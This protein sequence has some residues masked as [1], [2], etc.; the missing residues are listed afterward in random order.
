MTITQEIAKAQRAA[1]QVVLPRLPWGRGLLLSAA[2]LMLLFLTLP[3]VALVVRAAE[4]YTTWDLPASGIPEAIL[5]SAVTTTIAALLTVIFG[6]PLA[7]LLARHHFP[8]KALIV[9]LV[10][11][12]IVLPPAV[13]GLALLIAFGSQ[14]LLGPS[15]SSLGVRLPFS[16][17]AVMMVQVFVAAPFYIRAAIAAF[18]DIPHEIEDAARVDGASEREVFRWVTLPVVQSALVA[19]LLLSWSR[20]LGEFGATILFAGNLQGATQTMPL[21]IFSVLERGDLDTGIATGLILVVIALI[22]L[23]L[24]QWM[25]RKRSALVARKD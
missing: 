5:L 14:G 24:S 13:A 17:A 2:G 25:L 15:L 6:T 12:P 23:M 16:T 9:T 11:L 10:Q 22:T 20:A 18:E 8:G 19:G 3:L 21:L 1:D 4:T 7:F